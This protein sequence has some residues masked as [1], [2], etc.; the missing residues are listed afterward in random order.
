MSLKVHFALVN[1][2]LK[3][4]LKVEI[5]SKV[6]SQQSSLPESSTSNSLSKFLAV[7]LDLEIFSKRLNLRS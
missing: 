4:Y 2:T 5:C 6:G 1:L 3:I 7:W